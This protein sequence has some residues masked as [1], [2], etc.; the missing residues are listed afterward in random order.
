MFRSC[1]VAF[2][3][4]SVASAQ[5]EDAHLTILANQAGHTISRNFYGLMTEEINHAYDGGLYGELVQNRAL[6]DDPNFPV[7]WSIKGA[8]GRA[9]SLEHGDIPGTALTSYLR[10]DA[11]AAG[12]GREV[13]AAN[14]GY[15][16]IPVW[17]KQTYHASLY[18]KSPGSKGPLFLRIESATGQVL[19]EAV[20]P[21]VGTE[22][23]QYQAT[24]PIRADA[25]ST[26]NR[27]VVAAEAPGEYDL[28][29]VSLFPPTFHNRPNGNRSDIMALIGGMRP[30][31]LRLPGGNYLEGVSIADRFDWKKTLGDIAGRPGHQG[32]W[33]YR[34]SDGLGLLE[35]LEW[36]EDLKMEPLL[37]VYAGYSLGS[38]Y[39]SQ[40]GQ[41]V[42]AGPQLVPYVNDAL[43]EIEY[44]AG[45]VNTK[46]GARRALDGHPAPFPLH[47]VEIGNEDG[48]D[49]S[50]SY[51]A[52]FAQFYDAIKARY[53]SLQIIATTGVTSRKPDVMDDHYYR[54]AA[55]M[56]GDTHHYDGYD[57]S[58]P[59][60]F[61]GEWASV[62]GN[63]TP[64]LQAALGD[65]AWLT[66]LEANSDLVVMESYAPLLVNVNKGASQWGTNLIGYDALHSFGSP[67]YWVQ[68]LFADNTGERTVPSQLT[69]PP[70]PPAPPFHGAVGV[71]TYGTEAEFSDIKVTRG[72]ETL[73]APDLSSGVSAWQ[74]DAGTWSADG[75]VLRQTGDAN[76]TAI[77]IGDPA[78]T[79]Y[80]L[81]LRARKTGGREGFLIDFHA[82]GADGHW[83]W[84]IG[85]WGNSRTVIQHVQGN[86]WAEVGE[87]KPLS[88]ETNR[89]YN[90]DVD[91]ADGLVR[92]YLDGALVLST[93]ETTPFVDPLYSAVSYETK[94]G[95]LFVKVVNF[96]TSAEQVGID[97]QGTEAFAPI[98]RGWVITG[99]R[100]DQNSVIRPLDVAPKPV[101]LTGIGPNFSAT[102]PANSVTV[103]RLRRALAAAGTSN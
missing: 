22:W 97:I 16:G 67:S 43:D 83:T 4:A 68:R 54:S 9:L 63:P 88:V 19:G 75:G 87:S 95:D 90:I 85:G 44:V 42:P 39:V 77:T 38:E 14:E 62:E 47:Y 36:T 13:G 72:D 76:G 28:T 40:D 82:L 10:L 20:I 46:W 27:F 45:G 70:R 64:T 101:T 69:E 5:G 32:P 103:F 21:S 25:A 58:G 15:W 92:C 86:D 8:P 60:I 74:A 7:H 26:D 24:L 57:R 23:R 59:K 81:H 100:A 37:A 51:D 79:D 73:L 96:G 1:T 41:R 2:L 12:P 99:A 11:A 78:W 50:H 18:A 33:G 65:A 56:A 3:L 52:R 49:T 89:W 80:T 66:G 84:N 61:V 34:S 53:P 91:V 29:Q 93:K 55:A 6:A 94:H 30:S 31:F 71:G 35:F 98:A 48:F 17:P 102:F